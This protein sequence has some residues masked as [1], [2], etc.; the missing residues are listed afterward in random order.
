MREKTISA[1][2]CI[3]RTARGERHESTYEVY[4]N[5]NEKTTVGEIADFVEGMEKLWRTAI[6]AAKSY[7]NLNDITM[8]ISEAVYNLGEDGHD[9]KTESYDR[10]YMRNMDDICLEKGEESIYLVPDTRYTSE[11]RDMCLTKNVL[12]DMAFTMR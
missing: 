7:K 2:M 4:T 5:F 8:D 6:T 9:F 10:W 11:N 12:R 3:I 1:T